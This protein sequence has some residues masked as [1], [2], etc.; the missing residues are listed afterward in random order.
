MNNKII[1]YN[2]LYTQTFRMDDKEVG[3]SKLQN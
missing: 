1:K 3:C 2:F